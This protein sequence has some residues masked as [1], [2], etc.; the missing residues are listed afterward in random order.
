MNKYIK[1]FIKHLNKTWKNKLVAL[2]LVT[3][4]VISVPILDN[5][6][7]ILVLTILMGIPLIFE[8]E[9]CVLNW[10]D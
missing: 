6:G 5:D 2:S 10:R 1:N 3:L 8:K 7:T 9:N 4:G